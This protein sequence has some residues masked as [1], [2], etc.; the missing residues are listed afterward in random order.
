[1]LSSLVNIAEKVIDRVLPNAQAAADAKR[2]LAELNA[3]GEL[4]DAQNEVDLALAQIR[5]NEKAAENPSVFVSGG[6][7]AV[8][9]VCVF[10]LAYATIIYPFM[11]FWAMIFMD[12]PPEF[13]VISTAQLM[14]ILGSLL[15]FGAYRTF[16]K[17]KGVARGSL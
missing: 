1:M 4:A 13:P 17:I 8:I 9:W 16:E 6:R 3:R 2:L 11:I 5:V 7:P 12:T 10:A 15:G 14:P